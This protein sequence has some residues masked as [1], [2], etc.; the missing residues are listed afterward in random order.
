M[1]SCL[2][3]EALSSNACLEAR[4][5]RPTNGLFSPKTKTP[6]GPSGQDPPVYV[7]RQPYSNFPVNSTLSVYAQSPSEFYVSYMSL[8]NNAVFGAVLVARIQLQSAVGVFHAGL[9]V[10]QRK[11]RLRPSLRSH[12]SLG[13]RAPG[14]GAAL[15]CFRPL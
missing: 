4:F 7:P 9:E 1:A 12:V 2:K 5:P 10:V 15:C 11:L 3:K 8:C 14:S 6:Q 13:W